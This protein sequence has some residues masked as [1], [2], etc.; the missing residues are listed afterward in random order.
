MGDRFGLR[1]QSERVKSLTFIGFLRKLQGS[2]PGL[3]ECV[4]ERLRLRT[5]LKIHI[6]WLKVF[7]LGINWIFIKD[8]FQ[9]IF[10]KKT[11]LVILKIL[12][13]E[14]LDFDRENFFKVSP[15]CWHDWPNHYNF[16]FFNKEVIYWREKP[17]YN[18]SLHNQRGKHLKQRRSTMIPIMTIS[19]KKVMAS[20]CIDDKVRLFEDIAPI[21]LLILLLRFC[22]WY[23]YIWLL[24]CCY[25]YLCFCLWYV[26]VYTHTSI[27]RKQSIIR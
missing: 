16:F 7:F 3:N 1:L 26:C 9:N 6:K 18:H 25:F 4:R 2:I 12:Q 24:S 8:W 15:N 21:V 20:K 17:E 14:P 13:N 22:L 10:T 11:F 27:M 23:V 19:N 5:R